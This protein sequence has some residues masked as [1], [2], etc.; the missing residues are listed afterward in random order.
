MPDLTKMIL[1]IFG[2]IIALYIIITIFKSS[3]KKQQKNNVESIELG[4]SEE[5]MLSIM[6]TNYNKSLLKGFCKK[7]PS[8]T[9]N[10]R[11]CF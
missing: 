11:A 3:E 4:M 5:E 9:R 6:G 1:M 7:L 8:L 2:V 10:G